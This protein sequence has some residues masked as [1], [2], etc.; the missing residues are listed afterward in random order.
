MSLAADAL[1]VRE[2]YADV[3]RWAH[4]SE[5]HEFM[6]EE[7]LRRLQ[8]Y[9]AGEPLGLGVL[10]T[11]LAF[12][13]AWYA[14]EAVRHLTNGSTLA[15]QNLIWL[16]HR[17]AFWETEIA[18][19]AFNADKRLRRPPRLSLNDTSLN[20]AR[21]FS[22]GYS[23]DTTRLGRILLE[24]EKGGVFRKGDSRVGLFVQGLYEA[25]VGLAMSAKGASLMHQTYASIVE[26]WDGDSR[27]LG[28]LLFTACQLHLEG[29]GEPTDEESFEFS[30]QV[31]A[32]YPIEILM[33][34]RMRQLRQLPQPEVAHPLMSGPLGQLIDGERNDDTDLLR[35]V[36]ERAYR[37]LNV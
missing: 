18:S 17:H 11:R 2:L 1:R 10:L 29:A 26:A 19:L 25:W 16:S 20:L 3:L 34:L 15:F 14:A 23:E 35:R 21:A 30:D 9:A 33:V 27:E 37:D 28:N 13:A 7:P 32:I 36:V 5:N 22:L 12:L 24:G 8:S 6:F 31:F 4:R